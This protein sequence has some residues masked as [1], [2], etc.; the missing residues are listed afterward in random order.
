M[1]KMLENHTSEHF[2]YI[3]QWYAYLF[4]FYQQ[5]VC[6]RIKFFYLS[7]VT[8]EHVITKSKIVQRKKSFQKTN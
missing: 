6:V 2:L 5:V 3:T 7:H 4:I 8:K 1:N